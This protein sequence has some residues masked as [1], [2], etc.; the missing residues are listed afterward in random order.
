MS[1]VTNKDDG[2]EVEVFEGD[3]DF[4]HSQALSNG[5]QDDLQEDGDA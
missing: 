4:S 5:A 3:P 2:E 1:K